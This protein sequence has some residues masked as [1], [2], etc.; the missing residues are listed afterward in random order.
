M[1]FYVKVT[2]NP[3]SLLEDSLHAD[4]IELPIEDDFSLLMSTL[5]AQFPT[6][7]GLKYPNPESGA[8]RGVRM[9]D[10]SLHPPH[11]GWGDNIY[12]VVFPDTSNVSTGDSNK[13]KLE[14]GSNEIG[15][16]R[17][18]K[19]PRHGLGRTSRDS[20]PFTI[21]EVTAGV[22]D[23]IVL[24]LPFKASEQH[25]SDYFSEF[26]E[27]EYAEVKRDPIN[28]M[29][30][31]F[32]FIRFKSLE[33]RDAA[34][35]KKEHKILGRNLDVR[36][37]RKLEQHASKKVFVGQL[38]REL[39]PAE[40]RP[41]FEHYGTITD[42]YIP[43]PFRGFGF[44]TF[45]KVEDAQRALRNGAELCGTQLNVTQANPKPTT[46]QIRNWKSDR[47]S[48]DSQQNFYTGAMPSYAPAHS[49]YTNSASPTRYMYRSIP[50]NYNFPSK[51][52]SPMVR[53]A[54]PRGHPPHSAYSYAQT[55]SPGVAYTQTAMGYYTKSSPSEVKYGTYTDT[56]APGTCMP[57]Q[58]Y[59]WQ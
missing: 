53:I 4:V 39:T 44:V 59:Y 7:T 36:I 35:C 46:E 22:D 13:R 2:N 37:P 11:E 38:P 43:Q 55:P 14:S 34:L 47:E 42:V 16:D 26:G 49:N 6:S 21:G 25:M 17:A 5:Q 18:P 10:N 23:L 28:G 8:W 50:M 52:T 45:Q 27:L 20:S 41:P 32:G 48:D 51:M 9:T 58:Q 15:G 19:N 54:T 31:G 57:H 12:I 3:I 1:S 24:G 30:R 33:S 40:L 56:T 29:S